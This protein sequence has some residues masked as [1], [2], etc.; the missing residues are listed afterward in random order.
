MT[1]LRL[2]AVALLASAC[3]AGV[4]EP[5]AIDLANDVCAHCRM[6]ISSRATA[7]QIL[8]PGEE[9][10]LFDDLGCLKSDLARAVPP[11]GSVIVV[12]DHLTAEWLKLDEAVLTEVPG[13]QTPMGS[14][15]VAHRS[16]AARDS[17]LAAR[18]GRP[19]QVSALLGEGRP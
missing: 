5:V 17:D 19:Y 8:S 11:A 6:V 15:L 3:T 16:A 9:P 2:A 10:R 7:A 12:A 14:G 18:G 1:P 4:P 13:L